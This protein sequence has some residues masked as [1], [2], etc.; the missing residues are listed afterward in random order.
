M[1]ETE[2]LTEAQ[3]KEFNETMAQ[4]Y[5]T[6]EEDPLHILFRIFDRNGDGRISR[7]ELKLVM[8]TIDSEKNNEE[9]IEGMMREADTNHDGYI[10]VGEF[11]VVMKKHLN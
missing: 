1:S 3:V 10:D 11:V 7:A 9:A 2:P 4:F 8:D 5:E 6:G